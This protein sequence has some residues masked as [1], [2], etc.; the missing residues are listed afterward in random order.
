MIKCHQMRHPTSFP[1][2]SGLSS[3]AFFCNELT[4]HYLYLYDN[5]A[6]AIK[7]NMHVVLG[8]GTLNGVAK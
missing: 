8:K 3:V 7:T 1:V 6:E 5:E 2:Q 4:G